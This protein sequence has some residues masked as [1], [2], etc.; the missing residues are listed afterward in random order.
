MTE[1]KDAHLSRLMTLALV[2]DGHSGCMK[3]ETADALEE[4]GLIVSIYVGDHTQSWREA[5]ITDEGIRVVQA[6]LDAM[7]KA[8]EGTQQ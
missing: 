6:G 5:T 3:T 1:L 8:I 2:H 4:R 7:R